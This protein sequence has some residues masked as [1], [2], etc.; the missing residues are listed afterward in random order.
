MAA[1]RAST[2]PSVRLASNT[3]S[4]SSRTKA[5]GATGSASASPACS[6]ASAVGP[7]TYFM[8]EVTLRMR[9]TTR[10]SVTS[11]AAPRQAA[12]VAGTSTIARSASATS[13]AR[14]SISCGAV[15]RSRSRPT[16]AAR[17]SAEATRAK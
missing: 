6:S 5:A 2:V 3:C 11:R 16:I 17:T 14:S 9:D 10:L 12:C 15:R 8:R 7:T 4:F 13:P 1:V